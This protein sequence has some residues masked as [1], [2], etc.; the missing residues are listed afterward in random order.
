MRTEYFAGQMKY[1]P[2]P[3]A[4]LVGTSITAQDLFFNAPQRRRAFKSPSDEYN[5]A[6]DIASKYALHYGPRGV[7]ISCKK[8]DSASM[9]LQ[10]P[11]NSSQM[12]STIQH[13]YGSALTRDLVELHEIVD[14]KLG[15]SAS[16]WISTANWSSRKTSFICFINHRLVDCPHLKQAMES[17][18]GLI[19][20]K[21]RHPWIYLSIDVEPQRID[22]NVHPTKQEVHFLDEEDIFEIITTEAQ[23][24]L[25]SHT[26]CRVYSMNLPLG[27]VVDAD[28]VQITSMRR[29]DQKYDPRHLVRVD[30]QDQSLD[31]MLTIPHAPHMQG[32][33]RIPESDCHLTSVQELRTECKQDQDSHLTHLLQ[34]HTF[35]GVVDLEKGLSLV[36]HS[37]QLYLVH[38]AVLIEEF[39]YQLAL[40]QFGA[41]TSV[42]LDPPPKLVELIALGY[43]MEDAEEEKASLALSREQVVDKI[44]Q[45]ILQRADMLQDYFGIHLDKENGTVCAVPSLLPRHASFGLMLERLPSFFFRLGP[46]VDWSEEKGCFY[47]LC[48]ELA[49]CHV[50][51]SSGIYTPHVNQAMRDKETWTIQHVWFANMLGSRGRCIVPKWQAHDTIVQVASLPD[52]CTY[53]MTLTPDRVFERC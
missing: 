27:E 11:Q 26:S 20:P 35:V 46:Q 34:N 19:L 53:Y 33:E 51:P 28:R 23:K 44:A 42:R 45:V 43:D 39:C 6:L 37:T 2:K 14:S 24:L 36:Q 10:T 12:L 8:A 15:F 30:H 32:S 22:V 18:Y 48:R 38:H 41:Y 49:Y 52:L 4:G 5:R 31:S 29:Q 3:C 25:S 16:G 17:M 13:I 47:T 40:R 9:D 1:Q 50:P 7:G 21:G